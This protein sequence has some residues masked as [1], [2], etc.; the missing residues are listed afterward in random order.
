MHVIVCVYII[1]YLSHTNRSRTNVSTTAAFYT[2]YMHVHVLGLLWYVHMMNIHTCFHQTIGGCGVEQMAVA[3]SGD[4][5]L[6][7]LAGS[8]GEVFITATSAPLKSPVWTALDSNSSSDK[9]T[10]KRS[11]IYNVHVPYCR[12]LLWVKTFVNRRKYSIL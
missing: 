4:C 10:V 5:L 6:L 11:V 7:A 12:K 8:T 1:L 2:M 9:S 3:S